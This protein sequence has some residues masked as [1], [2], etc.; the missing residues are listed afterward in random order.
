MASNVH[1]ATTGRNG[2]VDNLAA[3][4]NSGFLKVYSGTQPANAN[5]ALSGNTLLVTHGFASTA[6]GASSSG[7]AT[8]GS[9]SS[10]VIAASGTATFAR[11]YESDGTTA[12]M[13]IS[14]GA[15]GCDLNYPT[16]TFTQNVTATISSL[17]LSIAA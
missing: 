17:T 3:R 4:L 9:I 16:A 5:T 7:T 11:L 10:G 13:D 8:A 1:V 14:V 12:V 6:F 15:S 2:M